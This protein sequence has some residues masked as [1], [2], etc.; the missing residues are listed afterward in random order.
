MQR[1]R[2]TGRREHQP[3]LVDPGAQRGAHRARRPLA[4]LLVEVAQDRLGLGLEPAG[5][6]GAVAHQ[7]GQCRGRHAVAGDVADQRQ[8]RRTGVEHLVEVAA[9]LD[10]LLDHGRLVQ[11]RDLPAG[12]LGQRMGIRLCASVSATSASI[13]CRRE[14]STATAA[15]RPS[16]SASA[17]SGSASRRSESDVRTRSRRSADRGSASARRSP[18]G[19]RARAAPATGL[20][21][22]R[23]GQVGLADLGP[24]C[25]VAGVDHAAGG[26]VLTGLVGLELGQLPGQVAQLA[27]C[28]ARRRPDRG[29]RRARRRARP[30]TSRPAPAP[31]PRRRC[32]ASA[33]SPATS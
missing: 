13:V 6:A 10:P 23:S 27:G 28:D 4:Q 29:D 3:S 1:R 20:G 12:Q 7:P 19:S 22:A 18:S 11:G 14:F 30:G 33:G 9:D 26:R 2:M 24:A 15:R 21:R 32:A 16:C 25:A 8:R 31:P 17:R 5:E